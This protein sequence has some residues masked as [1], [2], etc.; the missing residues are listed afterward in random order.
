MTLPPQESLAAL[1]LQES[2]GV[3]MPFN[4]SQLEIDT[5]QGENQELRGALEGAVWGLE[6]LLHNFA[7]LDGI[8]DDMGRQLLAVIAGARRAL[9]EKP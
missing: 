1:W 7:N 3:G 2:Q 5:V 4:W 8:P 9:E 6:Y